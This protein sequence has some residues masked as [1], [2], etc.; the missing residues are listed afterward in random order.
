MLGIIVAFLLLLRET[1][2]IFLVIGETQ[3]S[4]KRD[5]KNAILY[6]HCRECSSSAFLFSSLLFSLCYKK[7]S[8]LQGDLFY[9]KQQ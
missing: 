8:F 7:L 1:W 5:L 2:H 4:V 3:I 9:I 6:K